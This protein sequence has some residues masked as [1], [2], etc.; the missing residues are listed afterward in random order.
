MVR[1]VRLRFQEVMTERS[2]RRS[3]ELIGREVQTYHSQLMFDPSRMVEMFLAPA[4]PRA[5]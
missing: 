3:Q 2:A 4:D 1:Q 5:R